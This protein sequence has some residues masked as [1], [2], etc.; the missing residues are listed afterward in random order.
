MHIMYF[1]QCGTIN[2][3]HILPYKQVKANTEI[4][5]K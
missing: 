1:M 4:S 3:I 5:A 2:I